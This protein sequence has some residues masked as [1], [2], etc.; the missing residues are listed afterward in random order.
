MRTGRLI[1]A[2]TAAALMTVSAGALAGRA[3]GAATTRERSSAAAVQPGHGCQSGWQFVVA[4]S[5]PGSSVPIA[6]EDNGHLVSVSA[7]SPDEA[8]FSGYAGNEDENAQP[9]TLTW[10]GRSVTSSVL[11]AELPF[12]QSGWPDLTYD[13]ASFDSAADG[14]MLK[15][16]RVA[17]GFIDPDVS[18][19]ERW[20]DGR[21]VMT[22]MAVSPD[23]QTE[24]IWLQTVV[25]RSPADAWAA[26]A[27]YA[28]GPGNLYGLDPV[29]ALIEHWD[30]SQWSI[31]ANPAAAQAGAVILGLTV[32]SPDDIWA[33]GQQNASSGST[34]IPLIEHWNGTSWRRA[35][36]PAGSQASW[37]QAV[38]ADGGGDAWAVGYQA[39]PGGQ[40]TYVPLIERWDGTAWSVVSLPGGGAG[41]SGLSG[42]YAASASDVW[43]IFGGNQYAFG[44]AATG[45]TQALLHWDGRTWTTVP[46][47]GPQEY[48]LSYGY[49]AIGG[50]G[51]DDVWAA[52][53]ADASY[54]GDV[55]PVIAHLSCR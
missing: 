31:V 4:P 19:A 54:P 7:I 55:L 8:L 42:V 50:T 53:E 5:S 52:G 25:A 29:G 51:P 44:P 22:P 34:V 38:S 45:R 23:V 2:A 33:V 43:A 9:W 17:N 18:L 30:G 21:W 11:T 12:T 13:P 35:A 27:L 37:L 32:V 26:G 40:G 1:T 10:N 36:A 49:N 3:D 47:P 41:L 24:G 48:G 28:V 6:D 39:A 20:H 14:W 15:D 16:P 46:E